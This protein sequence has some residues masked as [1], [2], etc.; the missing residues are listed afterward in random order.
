M[1][2]DLDAHAEQAGHSNF[3][4]RLWELLSFAREMDRELCSALPEVST[5]DAWGQQRGA[6]R[7]FVTT[8]A[9]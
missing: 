3:D 4:Y 2:R 9:L 5:M 8:A 1:Y 6:I 7:E